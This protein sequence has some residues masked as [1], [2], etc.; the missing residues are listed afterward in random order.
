M[1]LR[2]SLTVLCVV[3]KTIVFL[4]GFLAIGI[5]SLYLLF[6]YSTHYRTEIEQWLSA[7]LQQT[8][9]IGAL[10]A[11]WLEGQPVLQLEQV[12]LLD[13]QQHTVLEVASVAVFFQLFASLQQQTAITA[14]IRLHMPRLTL[15]QQADG[16]VYIA[17]LALN[18]ADDNKQAPTQALQQISH[19]L[20]WL[21]QQ[22]FVSFDIDKL[23]FQQ[24]DKV[25]HVDA[26]RLQLTPQDQLQ[27]L[28]VIF[29]LPTQAQLP[30]SLQQVMLKAQLTLHPHRL[31]DIQAS[32]M[33]QATAQTALKGNLRFQADTEATQL[34]VN[35]LQLQTAHETWQFPALQL[36]APTIAEMIHQTEPNLPWQ[37]TLL[38]GAVNLSSWVGFLEFIPAS[39]TLRQSLATW[40]LTGAL[41]N[42]RLTYTPI[43]GWSGETEFNHLNVQAA[44]NLPRLVDA[45]GYTQFSMQQG[46]LR[47][48]QA[49]LVLKNPAWFSE[50]LVINQLQ[51]QWQWQWRRDAQAWQF[52]TQG[53]KVAD[54]FTKVNIVGRLEV[55]IQGELPSSDLQLLVEKGQVNQAYRYVPDKLTPITHAW[56]KKALVSGSIDSGQI[57][58]RGHWQTLFADKNP[59]WRVS[60]QI[61]N[62]YLHYDEQYPPIEKIQAEL[63]MHGREMVISADK[64]RIFNSQLQAVTVIIDDITAHP[65]VLTVRGELQ[66]T[67]ADGLH[68]LQDSPLNKSV[69]L[70]KD[71]QLSGDLGL[72]LDLQ[73]PLTDNAHAITRGEL[74]FSRT[75]FTHKALN[76]TLNQ[77]NGSVFF[78]ANKLLAQQL[79]GFLYDM[80]IQLAFQEDRQNP[81]KFIEAELTGR[82]NAQFIQRQLSSLSPAWENLPYH[83][84]ITGET[85]WR[86]A[87]KLPVNRQN[88][89]Q[90]K[91]EI[92]SDLKGLALK[93]PP[94]LAKAS[95]STRNLQITYEQ[96]QIEI[97]Y[98]NVFNGIFQ[99]DSQ[100]LNKAGIQFG[101]V[102]ASLPTPPII[103]IAGHL[104]EWTL[105]IWQPVIRAL[106]TTNQTHTL[107][108]YLDVNVGTLNAF[109]Y[110]TQD[111]QLN[112]HYQNNQLQL[113]LNNDDLRGQARW[114]MDKQQLNINFDKLLLIANPQTEREK[115]PTKDKQITRINPRQLPHIAFHA[116]ELQLD[117]I[118]LGNV[119]LFSH[120]TA[121]GLNLE[122]L[123]AKNAGFSLHVE[124]EWF[125]ENTTHQT[126]LKVD[127]YSQ[128]MSLLAHYLGYTASPIAGGMLQAN[129]Q[130]EWADTP[131]RFKLADLQGRLSLLLVDGHLTDV[132][133][134]VGRLFG[135]FDL[136]ALPRR[137]AMDFSDVFVAG[138]GFNQI[139]GEF[140]FQQGIAQTDKL[141][142]QAPAAQI[143]IQGQTNLLT[144][145][146]Q[147]T[148]TIIPHVSNTLSIAGT[149]VGGLAVGAVVMVVQK[150]L[151]TEI[152]KTINY[153][154]IISG[155]WQNPKITPVS[156]Q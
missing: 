138:F 71:I 32:F 74:R 49:G 36:Q 39:S 47:L 16:Q 81:N 130:A 124:G 129:L 133:P 58:V 109:G 82:A 120:P 76:V 18:I 65:A 154:Y 134:G 115:S 25:I 63:T 127:L 46:L 146:Y 50:P 24:P 79:N 105:A 101:G 45:Q 86:A 131:Y 102:V 104:S 20:Q 35:A 149:L 42:L 150:L 4:C 6:P 10:H 57:D 140:K 37:I 64:G 9:K 69:N 96:Q 99:I 55:P 41:Q 94:P 73:L 98:E 22:T 121:R 60:A 126:Q 11:S 75:D 12:R 28:H 125:A 141:V 137:L 87:L 13:A 7:Q 106:P 43:Q 92:F 132:E 103:Q 44:K 145:T 14:E 95:E 31:P 85:T 68:F 62:A 151:E 70:D 3:R 38:N 152:E 66:G 40:Q 54:N 93:L 8:V 110:R 128:D 90:Q 77:L 107:P 139:F 97:N 23:I 51:G 122:L 26:L 88:N 143:E 52:I 48:T 19:G 142:I 144:Q 117:K 114:D 17:G 34:T 84:W 1:L 91:I 156:Q 30:L 155:D 27:Q 112:A 119:N 53:F 59:Q 83:Q 56:L 15:S 61:S 89:A 123:E 33:L 29:T 5:L 100:G 80:P 118:Q 135:L 67:V 21:W 147:Q 153:Q 72:K 148:A 78:D 113:A 2:H 116:D 111:L 136:Q 108:I